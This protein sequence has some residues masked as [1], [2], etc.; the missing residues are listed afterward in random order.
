M[1]RRKWSGLPQDPDFPSDLTGLGYFVNENDEVRSIENPDNYYKFFIS[2]NSRWNERQRFAMNQAVQKIVWERLE[3]LGMKKML[4]TEDPQD[5]SQPHVPIF[6]SKDIESKSRVV[7][8]FGE[9]FQDLGVLAH[10]ILEGPGGVNK[11]SMVSIVS[12]LQKQRSSLADSSPPGIILA[13]M[14]ELIWWPE[15]GRTVSRGAF[16]SAPMTSAVHTS[17]IITDENRV[18]GNEDEKC[19]ITSIMNKAIPKI[20]NDQARVDILGVGDSADYMVEFLDLPCVWSYWGRRINCL[21]L[22]GG[23][24]PVWELQNKEFVEGFLRKKARTYV[25]STEPAGRI[26]S[27][28]D[29]NPKTSTFTQQGCLVFSSGEPH[30]IEKTLIEGRDMILGWLE[31]VA[32]NPEGPENYENPEFIVDFA[33]PGYTEEGEPGWGQWKDPESAG[34]KDEREEVDISNG[35]SGVEL[36]GADGDVGADVPRLIVMERLRGNQTAQDD[37]EVKD[38]EDKDEN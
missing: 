31:E 20:V 15:G 3:N 32:L 16:D 17:R 13:N 2:R 18:G 33:D 22:A 7:V 28:P 34:E 37:G 21:A 25:T 23:L 26:L 35:L 6:V 30:F 24:H 36:G 5:L 9:T 8:I 29:G 27:G 19:H 11:G 4:L 38:A 10:R 12:E 1:F 14:G